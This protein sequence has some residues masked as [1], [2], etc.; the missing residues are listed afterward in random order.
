MSAALT[1]SSSSSISKAFEGV[2]FRPSPFNNVKTSSTSTP[3][4]SLRRIRFHTPP[5]A[6][7][8]EDAE[9]LVH[10]T[11]SRPSASRPLI[12]EV[13]SRPRRSVPRPPSH[14]APS[15]RHSPRLEPIREVAETAIDF[16]H[17]KNFTTPPPFIRIS[18]TC[19][20]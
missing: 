10:S 3:P 20:V 2:R 11:P 6:A 14:A 12:R 15:S 8:I 1:S 19:D 17:A 18:T 9:E 4:S 7:L 5:L 16:V 13:A